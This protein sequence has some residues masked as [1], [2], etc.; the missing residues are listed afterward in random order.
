MIEHDLIKLM[1]QTKIQYID[2]FFEVSN[3][4]EEDEK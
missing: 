4:E 2:T 1:G 3:M